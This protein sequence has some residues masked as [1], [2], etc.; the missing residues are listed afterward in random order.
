LC[1]IQAGSIQAG[2]I[3]SSSIQS[4]CTDLKVIF[5]VFEQRTR[6]YVI[7]MQNRLKINFISAVVIVL[8]MALGPNTSNGQLPPE[9][10]NETELSLITVFPGSEI[11][12]AF[13]HSAFRF[14]DPGRYDIVFNYG[15]FDDTDPMFVPKFTYGKLDYMLSFS[16][17]RAQM[18]SAQYQRRSVVE[19]K[20]ALSPESSQALYARLVENY[21]PEN[22]YYRYDFLFENCATILRDL[23]TDSSNDVVRFDSSGTNKESFRELLQPY[24]NDRLFYD[25]GISVVLGSAVDR[26]T[27][28]EERSFLPL[29]LMHSFGAAAVISNSDSSGTVRRLVSSVDTL[30]SSNESPMSATR[31]LRLVWVL[32]ALGAVWILGSRRSRRKS[33]A[34]TLA[35]QPAASSAVKPRSYIGDRILFGVI[36]LAGLIIA[37][38]WF[39]SEHS[40]GAGN[41]NLLWALPT[42]ILIAILWRRIGNG[43]WRP[44]WLFTGTVAVL[45]LALQPFVSQPIHPA[46]FPLLLVILWRC[47][48][49]IAIRPQIHPSD[50]S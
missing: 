15:T 25:L 3:Q 37:F 14:F 42:H 12:S 24:L 7:E 1:S 13:G 38:V 27:T 29:E 30:Y 19:Q 50:R 47:S 8:T 5:S 31:D 20:L 2:S 22:R 39:I 17:M 49:L 26:G 36:G 16:S 4:I 35:S 9:L 43:I 40:V 6:Y 10:S 18:E 33:V 23:L 21:K 45:V 41:W 48:T 46:L 32:A 34:K 11:Y 44:Y 28:Y